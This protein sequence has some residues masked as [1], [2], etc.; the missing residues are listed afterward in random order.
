MSEHFSDL[1]KEQF[2]RLAVEAEKLGTLSD[3]QL[4]M[5]ALH[6]L[7]AVNDA[8]PIGRR[9]PLVAELSRRALLESDGG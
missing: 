8:V 7:I 5:H 9:L 4:I 6:E 3:S 2:A 1:T